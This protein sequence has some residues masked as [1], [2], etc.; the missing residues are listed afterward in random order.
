[1][2]TELTKQDWERSKGD[3]ELLIVN[4][5]MQIEMAKEVIKLCDKKINAFPDDDKEKE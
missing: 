3:N 5:R 4:N 2:E 1:M